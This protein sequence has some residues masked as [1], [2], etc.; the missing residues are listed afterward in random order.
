MLA[1]VHTGRSLRLCA[2]LSALLAA[3]ELYGEPAARF[4]ALSPASGW[5]HS[6]LVGN[7]TIG[8]MVE[9]KV[10]DELMHLSHAKLFLPQPVDSD[11]SVRDP[12][13]AACNL[14]IANSVGAVSNY[15]R[16][17]DFRTGE[18]V[19]EADD[20]DG[21]RYRRRVFASRADNIIA[22][23]IDDPA[24]RETFFVL[25]SLP[26]MGYRE[27]RTFESGVRRFE[28]GKRDGCLFYRCEFS[29]RNQ[30]N[31][32]AG[33]V[34]ALA[35]GADKTEAFVAIEPVPKD[36]FATDPFPAIRKRLGVAVAEG[37]DALLARHVDIMGELFDRVSLD[38]ECD[39]DRIPLYFAAGRYN[40][41]SS[42]GGD[43]IPNLQGLW[44]GSWNEAWGDIFRENGHL[45]CA[46]AFFSRGNTTEFNECLAKWTER[47]FK[48][49]RH[50]WH[51]ASWQMPGRMRDGY[52][53]TLDEAWLKRIEPLLKDATPR[54]EPSVDD[55]DGLVV[56]LYDD[57]PAEIVTNEAMVAAV[58]RT[59]DDRLAGAP[60]GERPK[61]FEYVQL[62]LAACK[63]GDADRAERCL[64]RLTEGYWTDGGGSFHDERSVFNMDISGGYPYLVSEMLVH[65]ED[66]W[67]SFLRAKPASWRRG[68][69]RGLRLRG[70][71]VVESLS[72]EGDSWSAIL[73]LKDGTR[74]TVAS[75][76]VPLGVVWY[77]K[78]K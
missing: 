53:H 27:A 14:R 35:A 75:E 30:W 52:R 74:T 7:G 63:L 73:R 59:I 41:I 68:V 61:A 56:A 15:R 29:N 13:M 3:A 4:E 71:V 67:A 42:T 51:G 40:I 9:G 19:V 70:A 32:L 12:F 64:A 25:D 78:L 11:R 31:D 16:F 21:R 17:V 5:Q 69:I 6:M 48:D 1:M 38:M 8:A 62:G 76:D 22:I 66:G 2:A 20:E 55:P 45:P 18:C 60:G 72:W 43:N 10:S 57:A 28:V 65:S 46:T 23:K 26:L 34:V 50:R 24:R 44:A 77:D 58:R 36:G 33:Y 39:D 54:P 47:K 49:P 37:Y